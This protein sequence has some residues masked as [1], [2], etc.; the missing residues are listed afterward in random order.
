M[1]Q[2]PRWRTIRLTPR[3]QPTTSTPRGESGATLI[4]AVLFVTVIVS[5]VIGLLGFAQVGA[6]SNRAYKVERTNR[7]GVEAAMNAGIQY[8]AL[9]PE[10]GITGSTTRCYVQVPLEGDVKIVVGNSYF[11]M[12]CAATTPSAGRAL[13]DSGKVVDGVQNPR[14]ITITIS[15]GNDAANPVR[16]GY[17]SC[18]TGTLVPVAKARVRFDRDSSLPADKSAVV[19]KVLSWELR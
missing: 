12:E 7:Y 5:L 4:I 15:C 18:G 8:L 1:T 3:R 10:M 19:P 6:R 17:A 2:A 9:K 11:T 16:V 14:D 13:S